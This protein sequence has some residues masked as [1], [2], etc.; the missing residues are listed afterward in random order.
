MRRVLDITLAL[1]GLFLLWL[2]MLL[3]AVAIRCESPGPVLFVQFRVGCNDSRF[4]IYKFR[5]FD[6]RASGSCAVTLRNDPRMTRIG[7][8]LERTKFDELPQLWNV[9]AGSMALVGPRP[10][11][12]DFADC[13][14]GP[15]RE[16]LRHKPGLFGPSQVLFRNES[17]L[18]P[19]GGDA[20]AFYRNFIFPAKARI[21]LMYYPERTLWSDI[22]WVA[23]GIMAVAGLRPIRGEPL[24][25]AEGN[26]DFLRPHLATRVMP[27]SVDGSSHA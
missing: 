19:S 17:L 23:C 1:L 10:E 25:M 26:L 20:N 5:K 12:L 16:V 15:A 4:R 6:R 22:G 8:V 21:D 24:V 9:L 2:P 27:T 7:R 18:Y 13:F 3:I 14:V 11:T